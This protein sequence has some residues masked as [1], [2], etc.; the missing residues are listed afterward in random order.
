VGLFS[1]AAK[2]AGNAVYNA[3]DRALDNWG[4]RNRR[5]LLLG[6]YATEEANIRTLVEQKR[7]EMEARAEAQRTAGHRTPITEWDEGW[8]GDQRCV[9]RLFEN[10]DRTKIEFF[11]GGVGGPL[12]YN[13]GHVIIRAGRTWLL[14]GAQGGQRIRLY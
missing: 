3:A 7:A 8:I 4:E 6:Q 1:W 12:G 13:H 2:A 14:P 11:Y 5:A 10:G 9:I